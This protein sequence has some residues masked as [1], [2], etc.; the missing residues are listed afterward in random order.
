[1]I[2]FELNGA[3]FTIAEDG[4]ISSADA[5]AMDLRICQLAAEEVWVGQLP[6]AYEVAAALKQRYGAKM[7]D[8]PTL[9]APTGDLVL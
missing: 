3:T 2:R 6:I 4:S 7:I 5:D 8:A 1:M 9:S